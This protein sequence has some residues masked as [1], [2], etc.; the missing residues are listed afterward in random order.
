MLH[1]DTVDTVNWRRN[2][3]WRKD[4]QIFP[5]IRQQDPHVR[6]SLAE[7][8]VLPFEDTGTRRGLQRR[9]FPSPPCSPAP[10]TELTPWPVTVPRTLL[11]SPELALEA[12]RVTCFPESSCPTKAAVSCKM[13]IKQAWLS[14]VTGSPSQYLRG[15][16]EAISPLQHIQR[17]IC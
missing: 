9:D 8:G 15:C 5:Q 14:L 10:S 17:G 11:P 16:Q 7:R 3:R 13:E 6:G 1:L 4:C 12:P 2:D